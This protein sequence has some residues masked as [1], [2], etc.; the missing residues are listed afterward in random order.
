ME[1]E[2]A[3][4]FSG[5]FYFEIPNTLG[6]EN[7]KSGSEIKIEWLKYNGIILSASTE[8]GQIVLQTPGPSEYDSVVIETQK[9]KLLLEFLNCYAKKPFFR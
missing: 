5:V 8:E 6:K 9:N 1:L 2:E 7:R 4:V 3:I